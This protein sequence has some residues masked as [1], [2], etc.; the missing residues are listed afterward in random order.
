MQS[1][2]LTVRDSFNEQVVK[3]GVSLGYLLFTTNLV[4][5]NNS[6]F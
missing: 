1:E 3:A 2:I 6:S 4:Y 5:V